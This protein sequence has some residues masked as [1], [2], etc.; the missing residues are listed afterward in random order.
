MQERQIFVATAQGRCRRQHADLGRRRRRLSPVALSVPH[1]PQL[2]IQDRVQVNQ[3]TQLHPKH[4][5]TFSTAFSPLL[6]P[7]LATNHLA[8]L[9][10]KKHFLN[11]HL[12]LDRQ[13]IDHTLTQNE[14]QMQKSTILNATTHNN[15]RVITLPRMNF[16]P[17]SDEVQ[18]S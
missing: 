10:L 14:R 6:S 8:T 12:S 15:F 18:S 3:S 17:A 1:R 13:S 4:A 5:P 16:E 9:S 11:T 2:L 7:R